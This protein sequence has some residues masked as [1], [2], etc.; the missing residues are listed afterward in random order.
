MKLIQWFATITKEQC[1]E[2]M[3]H[4]VNVKAIF[5]QQAFSC[6]EYFFLSDRMER[7]VSLLGCKDWFTQPTCSL[8]RSFPLLLGTYNSKTESFIVSL[9]LCGLELK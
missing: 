1:R 8:Q 6:S 4:Q 5:T 3:M 2:K 9:F 7:P